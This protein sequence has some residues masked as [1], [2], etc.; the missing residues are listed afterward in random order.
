M[1]RRWALSP[2]VFTVD[3]VMLLVK[4][5]TVVTVTVTVVGACTLT[6]YPNGKIPCDQGEACPTGFTCLDPK[7]TGTFT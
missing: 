2:S 3:A 7:R 6:P 1:K 5:A 4:T